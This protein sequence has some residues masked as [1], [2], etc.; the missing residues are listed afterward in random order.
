[1]ISELVICLILAL[2]FSNASIAPNNTIDVN[3]P[4]TTY[5]S[6]ELEDEFTTSCS[7][8]RVST[9]NAMY[10]FDL[11]YPKWNSSY[12]YGEFDCSEMSEY[13]SYYLNQCGI[14][15]TIKCGTTRIGRHAW[16]EVVDENNDI[17][18]IEPTNLKVKIP[19]YGYNGKDL[20]Y[21]DY[22]D[23]IP[24][25]Y[26]SL[27]KTEFDWWNS[28]FFETEYDSYVELSEKI[29]PAAIQVAEEK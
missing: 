2:P 24:F 27:H 23:A 3:Q 8:I 6:Q 12:E 28:K 17:I 21:D 1:M 20:T 9:Y 13:V 10:Y 14:K 15:N 16:I 18:I 22:F 7:S 4:T 25:S 26:T 5:I 29:S 11:C 19:G